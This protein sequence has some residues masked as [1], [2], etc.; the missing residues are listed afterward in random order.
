MLYIYIFQVIKSWKMKNANDPKS[1]GHC[2]V[3]SLS[4][5]TTH[6]TYIGVFFT[7]FPVHN[8]QDIPLQLSKTLTLYT[9]ID[10]IRYTHHLTNKLKIKSRI[11]PL[12]KIFLSIARFLLSCNAIK[13]FHIPTTTP[14]NILHAYSYILSDYKQ[15][16]FVVSYRNVCT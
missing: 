14:F 1:A 15:N 11:Y 2:P 4:F 3:S 5:L 13:F 8:F 9:L 7:L 12:G 10:W 16:H 6:F